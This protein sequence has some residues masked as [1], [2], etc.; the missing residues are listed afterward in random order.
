MV[1]HDSPYAELEHAGNPAEVIE[2]LVSQYRRERRPH[3][4]FEALKLRLRLRLGLPLAGDSHGTLAPAQDQ[5]LELG[6][7]EICREVGALLV[8]QG[9]LRE[10]WLYLR[11]VGDRQLGRRLLQNIPATEENSDDLVQILLYEAV[12]PGRGFRILLERNGICNSITAFDQALAQRPAS[13]QQPAAAVLLQKV[14]RELLDNVRTD[15]Q[16]RGG[17]APEQAPLSDLLAAYPQLTADGSYHLDTTHLMSTVRIARVLDDPPLLRMAWE[18]CQYGQGLHSQYHYPGDEPFEEFYRTHSL[19]FDALLGREVDAALAYFK[20]RA[21]D[22][23]SA[24][25]G[26][27][28]LETYLELLQRLGRSCEA[29]REA[30]RL[31]PDDFPRSRATHW[32]W[33]LSRACGDYSVMERIC[34]QRDDRLGFAMAVAAS[35]MRL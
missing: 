10:G 15:I 2:R 1:T 30:E 6:L 29:L 17:E 13:E 25:R 35:R 31:L 21:A 23:R 27:P 18:L 12:D 5:A 34:R 20:Q 19:W 28:A 32:L 9:Q 8:E 4:L 22:E 7:L 3:E 26:S 16:R 14:Y 24:E 11:P 33:D